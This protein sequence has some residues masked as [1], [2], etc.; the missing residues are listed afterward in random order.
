M[1]GLRDVPDTISGAM[2]YSL[3]AGGKRLRPVLLLAFAE[4]CGGQ[5]AH[6]L[7]FACAI[8]MIHT[9]SL[10]HDDLPCM[11]DDNL[12]RGRPTSHKVYGPAQAILAGDGLLTLAFETMAEP[13][14]FSLEGG[15]A[16]DRALRAVYSI[17][18]GAGESGMAGGQALDIEAVGLDVDIEHMTRIDR[19]KTGGLISAA[20]RAGCIVAG[21]PDAVCAAAK[22]YGTLLG[23]TFQI[24]DDILDLEGDP[25]LIGKATGSDERKD[26][27]T[28]TRLLGVQACRERARELTLDA[29]AALADF[30]RPGFFRELADYMS[31]RKA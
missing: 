4:A 28:Y 30:D 5:I 20:A 23:L 9:Y 26:K 15:A 2:N 29:K 13:G 19:M 22:R 10:I 12:R 31:D 25:G 7:P 1:N 24:Q 11:D 14:H 18:V 27:P 6:A 3:L 16:C 17:A 8:E 21:A